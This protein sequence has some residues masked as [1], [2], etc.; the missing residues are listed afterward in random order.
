MFHKRVVRQLIARYFT[1]QFIDGKQPPLSIDFMV[2]PD[3]NIPKFP[4]LI[5]EGSEGISR[6]IVS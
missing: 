4:W 5:I 1:N 3:M 6:S 2:E